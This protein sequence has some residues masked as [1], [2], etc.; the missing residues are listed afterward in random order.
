MIGG[1]IKALFNEG[2]GI[3]GSYAVSIY[4]F[5]EGVSESIGFVSMLAGSF[6]TY[7]LAKKNLADAEYRKAEAK[8]LLED[9]ND[10]RPENKA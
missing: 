2:L 4:S 6:L 1:K 8:R 9:E 3:A 5:A 7:S 10:D